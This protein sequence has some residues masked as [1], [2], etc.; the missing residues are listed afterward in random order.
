MPELGS[1]TVHYVDIKYIF[2]PKTLCLVREAAINRAQRP[3]FSGEIFL[4]GQALTPRPPSSSLKGR[5]KKNN[6]LRLPFT[7][8]LTLM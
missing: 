7:I 4:G 8:I 6:F 5:S 1:G 3:N 2:L